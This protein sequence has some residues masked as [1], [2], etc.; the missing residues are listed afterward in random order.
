LTVL[1]SASFYYF[2]TTYVTSSTI[3][4]TGSN[5][6]G[7]AVNDIQT[8]IGSVNIS[9]SLAVTG[10]TYL[11]ASNVTGGIQNYIPIW[12]TE[13]S[14]STSSLYETGSNILIGTTTNPNTN[15]KLY[16]S[17]NIGTPSFQISSV[18]SSN[19]EN[20]VGI[21]RPS[22]SQGNTHF[23]ELTGSD[24]KHKW[25]FRGITG[26]GN[27]RDWDENGASIVNINLGWN[28][29]DQT[30]F[31][32][33]TLLIDPHINVS[34]SNA[35]MLRGIYYN[36]TIS[37]SVNTNHIAIETATGSIIFRNLPTSS[38][39][40]NVLLYDS[41]SGQLY[42]TASNGIGGGS[43]TGAGFP[44]SGSAVITGSLLLSGSTPTLTVTGSINVSGSITGSLFGTS[45]W[46]NNSISSSYVTGSIFVSGNLATSASFALTAS[47]VQG[48][49]VN[50]IPL[51]NASTTLSTSSIY[52]TGSLLGIRT[53][54]PQYTLDVSG[55]GNY[56][57]GLIVSGTFV[58][59]TGST[60]FQVLPS[61]IKMGNAIGDMHMITGSLYVSGNLFL[62]GSTV[63]TGS[64]N[65]IGFERISGSLIITGSQSISSSTDNVLNI[66]GSGSVNPLFR[67][68]GSLGD[69]FL[70]SDSTSGSLFS[71]NN[72]SGLPIFEVFSDSTTK[73]GIYPIQAL[74]TT[75]QI[76]ANSG[77]QNTIYSLQTA[78][79]DGAFYD[80]TLRSGSHSRA[81]QI[82]AIWSG[83]SVNY[84]ETA[85]ADFGNTSGSIFSV[86]V[87]SSGYMNLNIEV[88]SNSWFI[89]T[90]IR[91]I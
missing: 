75:N 82:V 79:Y 11:T 66:Y 70:V 14:L 63:F 60:E 49:V 24:P 32:G 76:V 77:S 59:T 1:G 74:Y 55:S 31:T 84:T 44:F 30:F 18:S 64:L 19:N 7:D 58:V 22:G 35:T 27:K 85:T 72:D 10:S 15:F 69:M 81:G 34:G 52:Q 21:W 83:S 89:K 78:S 4:A 45:S 8:L 87:D 2:S 56:T 46:A 73:I 61:G 80:Y 37:A 67:V 6:F 5:T 16:V 3:T 50:Y 62:S 33:S 36:P 38:T 47:N 54:T 88:P 9:G 42:Y 39:V 23:L 26:F 71:V 41:A 40:T 68:Q 57:N 12:K 86:V 65:V 91:S 20:Y 17:G 48:G 29:P 28:S 13:N 25:V 90:I 51:W 43:G 53:T